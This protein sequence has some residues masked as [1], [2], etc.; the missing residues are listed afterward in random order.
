MKVKSR[1]DIR[2]KVTTVTRKQFQHLHFT[3]FGKEL[4]LTPDHHT[5]LS[6]QVTTAW[7]GSLVV[8]SSVS[9]SCVSIFIIQACAPGQKVHSLHQNRDWVNRLLRYFSTEVLYKL[10]SL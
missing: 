7:D 3:L 5:H 8:D 4:T 1:C 10:Q 2:L 9:C 6:T